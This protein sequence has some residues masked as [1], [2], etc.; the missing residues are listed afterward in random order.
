M[1]IL[2]KTAKLLETQIDEF[3]DA[4]SQGALVF[5]QG[6]KD[7]LGGEEANFEDH[8]EAISKLENNADDLRRKV[9]NYLYSHSLIP[10][11][12][13]DVLG[14][15]ES[16]DEVINTAKKTLV[17]FSIESPKIP[18]SLNKEFLELT[19]MS[20]MAADSIVYATR[21]FFRDI[22]AV[23]DHLHKVMF[24]EKEADRIEEKLNRKIFKMDIDLSQKIHLS[25]IVSH[26]GRVS[27]MA[28]TVGDRLAIYTIKRTI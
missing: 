13:G 17:R 14:L 2:F 9:E 10:E 21:A 6:I 25:Y 11:H 23:K 24:Y 8:I 15:L 5:E 12:R 22:N 28:E 18:T 1:A 26:I 20:I 27:D 3:L 19:E 4:V 7:Y 16:M